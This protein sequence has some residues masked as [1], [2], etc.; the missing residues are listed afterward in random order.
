MMHLKYVSV[1]QIISNKKNTVNASFTFD[2]KN[3]VNASFTFEVNY[4]SLT[5]CV[6][7]PHAEI[8]GIFLI[9]DTHERLYLVTEFS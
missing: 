6:L 7:S 1:P 4:T 2:K 9:S 8:S 5:P 3:T